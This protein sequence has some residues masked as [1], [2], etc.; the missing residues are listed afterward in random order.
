S[1][2]IIIESKRI[3]ENS[4]FISWGP[5]AGIDTFII[6]Y[7]TENG[8]WLYNT[9]ITGFSTTLHNLPLNQPVWVRIAARTEITIGIYGEPK[10]VGGPILPNTG[11]LHYANPSKWNLLTHNFL[12]ISVLQIFRSLPPISKDAS[13]RQNQIDDKV[14]LENP[15]R[16]LIPSLNVDTDIQLVGVTSQGVMESPS[17]T[18]DVGWF[19]LGPRPG[20]KGSAVI[21]GHVDG[22]HGEVG[23]FANLYKLKKGDKVYIRDSNE[24]SLTFIV[25]ESR[26]YDS[27]YAEEVFSR[28]DEASL[29]LITCDGVW[30]GVNKSYTKRLVV[31]TEIM[32]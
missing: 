11:R 21:A 14:S 17:N 29:N 24:K 18:I 12:G 30:D 1:A 28:N 3:D 5:Y 2:P 25:T 4:I 8:Q 13:P 19:D 27:G 9:N 6:E 10:F 23:V 31:F 32:H 20:E 15:V 16:L 26:R 22:E 7:G